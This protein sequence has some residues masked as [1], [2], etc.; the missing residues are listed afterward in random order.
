MMLVALSEWNSER[1]EQDE[2]PLR[3]GI[4]LNYGPVVVGDVG[5]RRSM[6][7]TVIGDTVNTA[8][9]LQDLTRE[10]HTGLLVSDNMVTEIMRHPHEEVSP[11]LA[12]L[13]EAG[14]KALR[15]RTGPIRVWT[16]DD[17]E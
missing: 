2:P 9:R 13:K 10:L 3:I 8:S 7:F 1:L 6:S 15:G 12:R 16:L 14:E 5:T 11:L 17:S 4:G